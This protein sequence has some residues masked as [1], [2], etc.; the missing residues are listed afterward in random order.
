MTYLSLFPKSLKEVFLTGGLVTLADTP[1]GVYEKTVGGCT[2]S[3]PMTVGNLSPDNADRVIQRNK[4]Y[5]SKYPRDAQ[6][7][8]MCLPLC[9]LLD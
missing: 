7:V 9:V 4:T 3:I 2:L 6:R 8:M 5:Y 1:D